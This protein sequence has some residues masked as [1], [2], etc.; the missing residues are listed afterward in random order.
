VKRPYFDGFPFPF[1][2]VIRD[3]Q[4]LPEVLADAL[5]QWFEAFAQ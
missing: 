4:T 3:I 2:L 5:R 1:Y